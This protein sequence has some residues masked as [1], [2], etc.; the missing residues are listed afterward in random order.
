MQMWMRYSRNCLL[1]DSPAQKIRE[2]RAMRGYLLEA[3]IQFALL[4][5]SISAEKG[6]HLVSSLSECSNRYRWDLEKKALS[7]MLKMCCLKLSFGEL[8]FDQFGTK[9]HY[10]QCKMRLWYTMKRATQWYKHKSM[11]VRTVLH[12]YIR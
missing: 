11:F 2:H 6:C 7:L 10:R 9:C 12:S 3:N 8:T 4:C 1:L 5:E